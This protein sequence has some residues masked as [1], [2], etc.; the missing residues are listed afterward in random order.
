MPL[1]SPTGDLNRAVK[2][3]ATPAPKPAMPVPVTNPPSMG[4]ANCVIPERDLT[5]VTPKEDGP[6]SE[7]PPQNNPNGQTVDI[8]GSLNGVDGSGDQPAQ[9]PKNAGQNQINEVDSSKAGP[10]PKSQQGQSPAGKPILTKVPTAE[11][12]KK[13]LGELLYKFNYTTGFH[14]H[15][16]EGDRAGAKAGS[17]FF[18]GRDGLKR[19]VN[20]KANEFGYQP[21]IKVEKVTP[22]E[23]PE[24]ETEKENKRHDY[25]FKWFFK[26]FE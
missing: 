6:T 23:T 21:S 15:N 1:V 8:R 9:N 18:I 26:N 24:P 11:Q 20:Y 2:P 12:M 17:Y 5:K 22:E 19:T 10:N 14:G 25:E 7:Q 16:E 3:V 4:C 13:M